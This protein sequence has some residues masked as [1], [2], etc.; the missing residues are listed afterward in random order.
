MRLSELLKLKQNRKRLECIRGNR[1]MVVPFVGAGISV[2]CG[3]YTWRQLLDCL[4]KEYLNS[5]EREKYIV[6]D[7]Y[8]QYAEAIVSAAGNT[9]AVMRRIEEI[10]V[11]TPIC[12]TKS[13][14]FLVSSFSNNIVTT[15]YD[16]VLE[17]A[18]EKIRN[19]R[20]FKILL[21]CL[22]GQMTAAIQENRP[23][24][25]KMHGSVEE[26]SSFVFTETQYDSFY[27]KAGEKTEKPLPMF[28]EMIFSGKSVLFVGCSLE[29]DRTID[30][31]AHCLKRNR[32]IK[33]Y[34]I[35]EL[36][37]DEEEEIRQRNHLTSLGIEPIYF[38]QGDYDSV[39]LL[40]EYLAED[41][42]F[43]QEAKELL[44]KYFIE[45]NMDLNS[46]IYN[47]LVSI[48]NESFYNTA[49]EFP[50]L[51]ELTRE[52]LNIVEAY[53]S[54]IDS[55]ENV[56]KSLY[57]ICLHM[58]ESLARSGIKSA[59][60]IRINLTN[61]FTDA[62]LRETDITRILQKHHKIYE[63]ASLKM[64]GKTNIELTRLADELNRKIQFENEMGFRH[65][66][67]YYNQAIE[68]LDY[69]YERIAL[70]QRV[71]L[72]NTI[73]AWGIYVRDSKNPLKYLKLAIK[74]VE[75]LGENEK[76]YSV[77]SQCYCN[78]GLLKSGVEGDY[79]A[80][81]ECARKDIEYKCKIGINP[82]L[83]AGSMGHYGLYQKEIDPFEALKIHMDTI[84]LK[85]E[86]IERADELRFERD[87]NVDT[88]TIRKKLIASWA[89]SVFDLGLL[90][91]DM[92]LYE[93][94]NDFISIANYC[95]YQIV[96]EYS[97]DYNAS[98]NVEA[99]VQ[100][101]LHKNQDIR[102]FIAA[103]EKRVQINP[104]LSTTIYHSWYVCALYF[105]CH[106]DYRAAK[107]YI[108]EF[109]KEYYFKGDVKDVRQEVRAKLLE[110]QILLKDGSTMV[111]VQTVLDD[112]INKIKKQYG[113]DSFWLIEL[114]TIYNYI[115]N[116]Y[117]R[118]LA[119]LKEQYVFKR[120]KSVIQLKQFFQ[121]IIVTKPKHE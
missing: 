17:L 96:D 90:A 102:K 57:D 111:Q 107:H 32:A 82:R 21:P 76:S 62:A 12:L 63:P 35:V 121:E 59:Q 85:R 81:I 120:E 109:Y 23:C 104:A 39:E 13:P 88:G 78:L 70:H 52:R 115:D 9:D 71:L 89:T 75:S 29:K 20:K 77:L 58:F 79:L 99:E 1:K 54:M 10:F 47:L 116:R 14:Y 53:K 41:N 93:A 108:R 84:T 2:A 73:G 74:T 38:P 94:A 49:K 34:A 26:S 50:E 16:T 110:A 56:S 114:Y 44:N 83:L 37:K 87:K 69:A 24:I 97:K 119:K 91:K 65:F 5:A 31:L 18:A 66:M 11:E 92:M 105:F 42:S 72:C 100:I 19:E 112:A 51:F 61:Y 40:L 36:P 55:S 4:A 101:L 113:K 22:T 117:H 103:V 30:I 28:L 95:R 27:G 48:L 67:D 64:E 60:D 3:L 45:N 68:L 46:D 7:N 15:N 118:E 43:I 33:H 8:L 106:E 25:M 80:A 98:C 6:S 86:N